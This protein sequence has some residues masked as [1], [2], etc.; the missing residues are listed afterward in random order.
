M[1]NISNRFIIIIQTIQNFVY[2][3]LMVERLT[4]SSKLIGTTIDKLHIF[5][6]CLRT[7]DGVLKLILNL[8]NMLTRL[9]SICVLK[10]EPRITR[11]GGL[12]NQENQRSRN[13]TNK[14]TKKKFVLSNVREKIRICSVLVNG[15]SRGQWTRV[16]AIDKFVEVVVNEDSFNLKLPG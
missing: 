8:L 9:T 3:V 12:L 11:G 10:C 16:R 6:D 1:D 2:K 5:G 15:A 13:R 4:K 7:F 14:S